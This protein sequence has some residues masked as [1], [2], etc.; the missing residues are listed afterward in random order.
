MNEIR[1]SRSDA[2]RF[3]NP[4]CYQHPPPPA[5]YPSL[6]SNGF[7]RHYFQ[8]P[9]PK[10]RPLKLSWNGECESA[11][12]SDH[13]N[14]SEHERGYEYEHGCENGSEH[15]NGSEYEDEFERSSSALG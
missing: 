3:T 1:E 2:V 14:G 5:Q 13:E 10:P 15:E 8:N 7:R 9:L 4:K 6:A 11:T 12:W